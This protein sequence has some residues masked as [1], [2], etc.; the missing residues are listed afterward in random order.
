MI[1]SIDKNK[2]KKI[3]EICCD[4]FNTK[5]ID[6]I[7]AITNGYG[8]ECYL[9]Q[10]KYKR[11]LFK[12]NLRHCTKEDIENEVYANRLLFEKIMVPNIYYMGCL[13]DSN[14]WFYIQEYMEGEDAAKKLK[15]STRK[16]QMQF[17]KE[18]GNV[19]A[20]MHLISGSFFSEDLLGY[21]K[22]ESLNNY[23]QTRFERSVRNIRLN[24]LVSE[25]Q[26]DYVVKRMHTIYNLEWANG[27]IPS[28]NHGDLHLGNIIIDKHNKINA[29]IDFESSKFTD[30]LFDFIKLYLW[31][32]S[33]YNEYETAFM[34]EY[35]MIK[36][37]PSDFEE[38]IH[39]YRGIEI[40]HFIYYF[41][42]RFPDKK[43]F[44]YFIQEMFNWCR[45]E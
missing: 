42:S 32:F 28:F 13:P 18:F 41:G 43:M 9:V 6:Q 17:F 45:R 16:E 40:L 20:R 38:R 12:I 3:R 23:C 24:N 22:R 39:V 44:D 7:F 30:P 21:R 14:R 25:K 31:V 36:K 35:T 4:I 10:I 1:A 33:K 19:T 15:K 5:D 11:Y 27:I 8:H 29:V 37:T 34:E 2:V 26:L